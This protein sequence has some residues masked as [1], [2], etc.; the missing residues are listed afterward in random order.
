MPKSA[1][2]VR[3]TGHCLSFCLQVPVW[4]GPMSGCQQD[5]ELF[6]TSWWCGS[7]HGVPLG[8]PSREFSGWQWRCWFDHSPGMCS[9]H[10][11]VGPSLA[12]WRLGLRGGP[13]PHRSIQ[14]L[15][16]WGIRMCASSLQLSPCVGCAG[17][18]LEFHW[19]WHWRVGTRISVYGGIHQ[20]ISQCQ[21]QQV[22]VHVSRRTPSLEIYFWWFVAVG[23]SLD[24]NSSSTA[25]PILEGHQGPPGVRL[26]LPAIISLC[27]WDSHPRIVW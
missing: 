8:I 20:G 1:R 23:I 21:F 24:G 12:C 3:G 6:C 17:G 4:C 11:G 5:H 15:G 22:C 7:S 26:H 16:G 9:G 13:I 10:T 14:G 25:V 27:R 18:R 19:P 2:M